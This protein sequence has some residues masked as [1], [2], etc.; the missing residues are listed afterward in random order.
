VLLA[1]TVVVEHGGPPWSVPAVTAPVVALVT[2][3]IS[4]IEAVPGVDGVHHPA[5][6][7]QVASVV[8]R[9][10]LV[11]RYRITCPP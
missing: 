2:A 4:Y 9:E 11:L 7:A 5:V 10:R 3:V 8:P 1:R 6:N